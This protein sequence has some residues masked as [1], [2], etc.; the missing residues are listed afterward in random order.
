MTA[1]IKYRDTQIEMRPAPDTGGEMKG[2][3]AVI[4]GQWTSRV[5]PYAQHALNAAKER[6]DAQEQFNR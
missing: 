2:W 6:I 5:Y 4:P 1:K 3:Y